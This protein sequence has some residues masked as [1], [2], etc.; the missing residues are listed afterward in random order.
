MRGGQL[1]IVTKWMQEQ[2]IPGTQLYLT[3][4]FNG[5]TKYHLL[6]KQ[7]DGSFLLQQAG[8]DETLVPGLP[9]DQVGAWVEVALA[10]PD[11]WK[12]A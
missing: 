3:Y 2:G 4:Y 12:G 11:K 7:D 6:N 5:I 9:V 10:H 8:T 1:T